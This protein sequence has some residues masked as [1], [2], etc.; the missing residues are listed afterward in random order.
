MPQ[1]YLILLKRGTREDL[2]VLATGEPA[3][4]TDTHELFI[5]TSSGINKKI[6]DLSDYLSSEEL[7]DLLNLKANQVDVDDILN[8]LDWTREV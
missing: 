6:G 7:T 5:G 2:P 1:H 4:T 8:S 3:F